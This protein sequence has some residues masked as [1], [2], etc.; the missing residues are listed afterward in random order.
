MPIDKRASILWRH[1]FIDSI[2]SPPRRIARISGDRSNATCWKFTELENESCALKTYSTPARPSAV[3][4][5]V[6]RY[7]IPPSSIASVEGSIAAEPCA[8]QLS[9]AVS[10]RRSSTL[11]CWSH[12]FSAVNVR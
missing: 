5:P 3:F 2:T 7:G 6:C 12:L 11:P 8:S 1:T 10:R 4:A 9:R